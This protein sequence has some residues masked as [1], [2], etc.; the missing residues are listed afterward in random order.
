MFRRSSRKRK[1]EEGFTLL[2]MVVAVLI[3]SVM[4]AVIVPHLTGIGDRADKAA[5]A[6]NQKAI[7]GALTEYYL[8]YHQYPAGDTSE[9]L[10]T[11][12]EDKLLES[13]PKEPSGGSY[14][15]DDTDPT[16]VVVMCSVHGALG[17]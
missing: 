12:V 11:L 1:A 5:C 4:T 7:R 3:V 13:V 9:Q 8:I 17:V 14:E 16:Q 6:Q 10:Q 15:I 2:E